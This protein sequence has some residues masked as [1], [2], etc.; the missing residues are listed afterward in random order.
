VALSYHTGEGTLIG[1]AAFVAIQIKCRPEESAF[2]FNNP[3]LS[4]E[5]KAGKVLMDVRKNHLGSVQVRE[6]EHHLL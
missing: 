6:K 5:R 1:K 4:A 2:V 3:Q